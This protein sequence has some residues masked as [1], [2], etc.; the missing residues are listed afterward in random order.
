M[1]LVEK[2]RVTMLDAE[3]GIGTLNRTLFH[4]YLVVMKIRPG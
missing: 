1:N 3:E 4:D 2:K